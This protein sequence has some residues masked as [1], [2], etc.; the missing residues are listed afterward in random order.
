MEAIIEHQPLPSTI[1][2][3]ALPKDREQWPHTAGAAHDA[4]LKDLNRWSR[5]NDWPSTLN[6]WVAEEAIR[7]GF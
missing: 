6:S 2:V 1:A 4:L 5:D 7:R 3:G